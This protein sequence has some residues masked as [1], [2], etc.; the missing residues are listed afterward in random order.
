MSFNSAATFTNIICAGDTTGSINFSVSG[1]TAPYL[2]S[3]TGGTP[4]T[5]TTGTEAI[6]GL[7]AG[8]YNLVIKDSTPNTCT[9]SN[10]ITQQIIITEPVG[11]ALELSESTIVEIPCSGGTGSF[12]VNVTG[13]AAETVSGTINANTLYQ[14]RVVGPGSNYILNTTHDRS[15]SSFKVDNLIIIG[16][17]DVTVT[18]SNGCAQTITVTVPTSAPDNLGATAIVETASGCSLE[19]FSD[20]NT[21][22]SIHQTKFL[23]TQMNLG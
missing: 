20:G 22:A 7:A 16:N 21:G 6:T 4:S 10:T 14:V 18:D 2:Y 8:T 23:M 5:P 12:D 13:G 17:Y 19:T 3:I 11:G 1:G 15:L 9:G